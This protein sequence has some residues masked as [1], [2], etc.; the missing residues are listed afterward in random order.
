MGSTERLLELTAVDI[1]VRMLLVGI[2]DTTA[3]AS[4]VTV[5][6]ADIVSEPSGLATPV[7]R[8]ISLPGVSSTT[9]ETEGLEA[10]GLEG[11][12]ASQ[13][14]KISP[15]DFV[16]VL[17]LDGPKK[18]ASLVQADIVGPAVERSKALLAL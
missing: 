18:A 15:G 10:H 9:S 11:D 3:T 13:E 7:G 1:L 12:I 8:L 4:G 2:D 5:S 6:V 16:A 14:Q 17:L